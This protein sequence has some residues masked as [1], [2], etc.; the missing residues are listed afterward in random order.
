MQ[1]SSKTISA[2]LQLV[3]A[4]K[5]NLKKAY[6]DLQSH[7]SLLSSSFFLPS[8]SHID[9]HF[10]SMHN[11][12]SERF[13]LLQTL[14]SQEQHTHPPS[15]P[16]KDPTF[17]PSRSDPSSQN[18]VALPKPH[19]ERIIA[20]CSSVDGKGLRD[21]VGDHFK[22]KVA[23]EVDIQTALKRASD[24]ASMILDAL[25]GVVGANVVKDDKELRKRKRTCGFLFQQLRAASVYV[26]FDVLKRARRLCV[27]WKGSL[28]SEGGEGVGAMTFLQ[29]V[30]AYGLFSELTDNE[31]VT[32][33][34]MAAGN[35]DLPELYRSMG[36]TEKVP[37]LI[38][39]LV[40]RCRHI[41]A[42]KYIFE[43]NLADKIPP[44][45]IL[46]AHVNE[47][48][49]LAKK[50]S[51]EGKS[52]NEIIAREVHALKSAIKVIE[53]H[54][55]QSQY[56]PESLQQ[57]L[58]QLTKQKTNLKYAAS[59]FSARP[60]SHQQQQSAI[61]RPRISAPIGSA[62]VLNSV[63]GASSTAHHYKHPHFQS[64]G[65][66][67]EQQ[68]FFRSP[69]LLLEQQPHFQS[70]GLLPDQQPRFQSPGLLLEHR[71]PYINLPTM[72]YG[73][74]AQTPTILPYTGAATGPYGLGDVPMGSSGNLGQR[75][76]LPNSSEPGFH[77]S[78][79][80]YGGYGLQRYHRTSYPQ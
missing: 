12:L 43:F 20:L 38:Q 60:P 48:Q 77:D 31:I 21:Y 76:S 24:P 17:P 54:N 69:G 41:L 55:L 30:A 56:P 23:F 13:H 66:L 5:E 16:S 2:A 58:E 15:S 22:E 78:V 39:K 33:S 4:K 7:S 61:K 59:A 62:A 73:M 25:D 42:V 34:A 32:F 71:S 6:D 27:E 44:I 40:D 28:P 63:G 9:S 35:D 11:S 74:N 37:G 50:L 36:L 51:E 26:S 18:D 45:P 52:P 14:E 57:R 72:S 75:G 8:W 3:D 79:S 70:S 49:K 47:S 19:A 65:L 64:S 68:P 10:T 53:S 80:A 46:K 67:P 1:T 29:F